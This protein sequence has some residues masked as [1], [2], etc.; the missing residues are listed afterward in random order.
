MIIVIEVEESGNC[1]MSFSRGFDTLGEP[2]PVSRVKTVGPDGRE[3]LYQVVGWT[4]DGPAPAYA[5]MV[6]DSG[7]GAALLVYGADEGV[8]LRPKGSPEPW[9][10]PISGETRCCSWIR[11]PR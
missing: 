1:P 9:R 4:V 3:D 7:E 2:R 10:A 5:V 6:E 8:R 11:R